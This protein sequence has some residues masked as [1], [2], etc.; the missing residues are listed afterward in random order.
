MS[1]P[2]STYVAGI[3]GL[4]DQSFI[5]CHRM[6]NRRRPRTWGSDNESEKAAMLR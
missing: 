6:G 5:I 2:R 3:K 1:V 4:R